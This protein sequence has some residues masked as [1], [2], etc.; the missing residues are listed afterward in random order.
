MEEKPYIKFLSTVDGLSDIKDCVPKPMQKSIPDW[1]KAAPHIGTELS[2][3]GIVPGN[4]KTCPSFTDYFS[5]GYTIPMWADSIIKYDPETEVWQ[6]RVASPLFSWE[7]HAHKQ[8]LEYVP[9]KYRGLDSYFVFKA[10]TPW[11]II[12]PPGYSTLQL[13]VFFDFN[14]DI[15]LV[16]GIRDTDIYHNVSLQ[17]LV[18]SPKKEIFIKRGT[19]IAHVVPFK[20]LETELVIGDFSRASEEDQAKVHKQDLDFF[21]TQFLGTHQYI[22]TR[23]D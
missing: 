21:G 15:S 3:D 2:V 6:Y 4:F 13:P 10:V 7:Y 9:H 19:P 11:K 8:Y 5:F 1:W 18:H 12:T 20:R 22:N 14:E 23:K 17:L 16:P